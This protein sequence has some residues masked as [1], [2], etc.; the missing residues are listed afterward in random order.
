MDRSQA[1]DLV[2]Y[3]RSLCP[4]Q[5]FSE[6]TPIAWAD[7]LSDYS[8]PECQAAARKLAAG[9]PF[10]APS[11][12]IGEVKAVR[13]ARLVALPPENVVPNVDPDF[14]AEYAAEQRAIANA[15]ADGRLTADKV[16]DYYAWGKSLAGA[17]GAAVKA[18]SRPRLSSGRL[19]GCR[20]RLRRRRR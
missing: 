8:L 12:I 6:M 18:V 2:E 13:T 4:S 10:I 19:P 9:K 1:V 3:V 14:P 15:I 11:E 5:H 20:R 16:R 7:V 17:E